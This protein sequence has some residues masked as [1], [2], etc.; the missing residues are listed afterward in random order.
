[1]ITVRCMVCRRRLNTTKSLIVHYLKGH[2]KLKIIKHL[3]K[4][5]IIQSTQVL[6]NYL[7]IKR[8]K[9]IRK[10]TRKVLLNSESLQTETLYLNENIRILCGPNEVIIGDSKSSVDTEFSFQDSST[11][12]KKNMKS[13]KRGS[14]DLD[15]GDD[16]NNANPK[17]LQ[18]SC[19]PSAS[20]EGS[21]SSHPIYKRKIKRK[22]NFPKK[23]QQRHYRIDIT[24]LQNAQ[25]L[26]EKN[27]HF[28]TC[29][30]REKKY[31]EPNNV[32][33]KGDLRII[34]S[35]TESCSDSGKY[36]FMP[37]VDTKVFCQKCGSGYKTEEELVDHMY[38]HESF[39]RLCNIPFACE[40]SFKQHMQLHVF[41]LFV[42][43][44]CHAEFP[45]KDML[46]RHF[47]CHVEDRTFENVLDME[48]DY[49]M[50][51]YNFMSRNYR[52]S[53]N[54]IL[55]FL[56]DLPDIYYCSYRFS[57]IVCDICYAE[58]YFYEYE[59]HLQSCHNY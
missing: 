19:S 54:S 52:S 39:C 28:Y 9:N 29:H 16:N 24:K 31:R 26:D 33:Q 30:C 58:V 53:I 41:R 20:S 11:E 38:V 21:N 42:C 44:V 6:R 17:C 46:L 37:I 47:D 10:P 59:R 49:R 57:K 15:N 32:L 40:F 7:P 55:R 34:T 48:E 4:V 14:Q 45:F 36:S 35:D 51:R 43:H 18:I 56:G 23:A 13:R 22:K 8:R 2:S 27:G 3:L 50:C 1:M 12:T 25:S 5:S